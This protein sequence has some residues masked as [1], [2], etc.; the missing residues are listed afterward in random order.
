MPYLI[1][2]T[3]RVGV[4]PESAIR[5]FPAD[6]GIVAVELPF[7]R[8]QLVESLWW[9]PLHEHDPAH[10]WLRRTAAEAGRLVTASTGQTAS[11]GT[12]RT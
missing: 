10:T 12:P 2:G 8:G 9:H 4:V 1:V 6:N 3:D 7:C 5:L 11:S